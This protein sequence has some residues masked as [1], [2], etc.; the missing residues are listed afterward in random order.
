MPKHR[1]PMDEWIS[2]VKKALPK[3]VPLETERPIKFIHAAD[4][5]FVETEYRPGHE[6]EPEPEEEPTPAEEP[7][8]EPAPITTERIPDE[9][10]TKKKLIKHAKKLGVYTKDMEKRSYTKAKILKML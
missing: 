7:T 2:G 8:E 5:M 4:C 6:P 9:T 10:W 3:Y 1:I